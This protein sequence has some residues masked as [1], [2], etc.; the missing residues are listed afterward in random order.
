ME[1]VHVLGMVLLLY[2]CIKL[3]IGLLAVALP[4]ELRQKAQK[5]RF[6]KDFIAKDA[7]LAGK[8]MDVSIIVFAV[9]SIFRG[10]YL[11]KVYDHQTFKGMMESQHIVYVLYGIMGTFLVVFYYYVLY[12]DYKIENDAAE[13][14]TYKLMGIGTG[15]FFLLVALCTFTYHHYKVLDPIFF[16]VLFI[17]FVTLVAA[18]VLLVRESYDKIRA[19]KN[20][21]VT[22]LMIPLGT[23]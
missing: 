9:Y 20:E 7:T 18:F 6:V 11:L 17:V 21:L 23:A 12:G 13:H 15:L 5:Y 19:K 14:P 1:W 4:A 10:I 3:C 22:M 16:V 8:A 2:G